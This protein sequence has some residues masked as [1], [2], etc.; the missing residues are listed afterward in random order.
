MADR[1]RG[2]R[3]RGGI[4]VGVHL[5]SSKVANRPQWGILWGALIAVIGLALLVD[6]LNIFP[7]IRLYR[8]WP[9]ILVVIG[10]MNI[11]CRSGRFFGVI[12][13]ILGAMFQLNELGYAHFGWNQIWPIVLISVGLLVMW[14]SLEARRRL[15]SPQSSNNEASATASVGD[16]R[17]LLNEVAI[18]GGVDRRVVTHDFR[19]GAINAIFG[20]VEL[21]LSHA[22]MIQ[23]QAE[24]EVNAIFGGV[25]LRVPD[26]WRVVSRN[27]AIFGGYDDKTGTSDLPDNPDSPRKTLILTGSVIFGGVEIKS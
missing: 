13:L 14:S 3:Q 8:F 6:N 24:L 11:A 19:G 22:E 23:P 4:V 1:E 9:I 18:F 25:E 5:G 26:E 15:A 2:H 17:D 21:D 10:L 27:Q 12:L 20:G 7:G 16:S